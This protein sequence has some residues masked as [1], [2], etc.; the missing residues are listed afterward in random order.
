MNFRAGPSA[1]YLPF[2]A[3]PGVTDS[4]FDTLLHNTASNSYRDTADISLM[5]DCP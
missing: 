3:Q 1:S 2:N 4:L 5:Y